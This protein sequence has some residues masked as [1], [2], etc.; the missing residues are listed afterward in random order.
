MQ[1]RIVFPNLTGNH[2][3]K[4]MLGSDLAHGRSAH[5]YILE[6]PA[7]SGKHTLARLICA[8]VL[9]ENRLQPSHSLPCGECSTCRKILGNFSVDILTVSNEDKASIGVDAIR[10]IKQSLYVTPNDGEKKF[11]LIENAHLMTVQ[12]QNALLLSLEE[13]PPYV[14][15][16]LLC[17]DAS[18]LLE[19][20]RSRAPVIRMERF[21][22]DF[23]EAFLTEK[24][25]SRASRD[26]IVRAAHLAGGTIGQATAL[27]EHGEAEQKLYETAG[28]LVR[29]LLAAKKSEALVFATKSM[30]KERKSTREVL[31][32]ARCAL[33]DILAEKKGADLLFYSSADGIPAYTR[34]VSARR[35]MELSAMLAQAEEDIGANVSQSAILTALIMNS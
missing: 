23:L 34:K 5:A 28:E 29:H 17:E 16:L 3:V 11:Y 21:G 15:F 22:A 24:Y 4:E 6:G 8:S 32:L 14:L 18:A 27:Y 30:P 20:I 2:A 13:P 12:A 7:G 35:V 19:T 25:G 33:R 10:T 31:S 26:R 9:C 1:D